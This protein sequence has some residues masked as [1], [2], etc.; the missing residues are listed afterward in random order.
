M[1]RWILALL[2][3]PFLVAIIPVKYPCT[4]KIVAR[5]EPLVL[6]V[7]AGHGGAVV[8]YLIS[9]TTGFLGTHSGSSFVQFLGEFPLE[10]FPFD[11][12]YFWI[13]PFLPHL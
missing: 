4:L 12:Q 13:W 3:F 11:L 8:R 1:N 5:G 10:P 2:I 9:E 7:V 6:L